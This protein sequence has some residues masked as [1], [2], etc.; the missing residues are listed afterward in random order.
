ML[1][2][3]Y[4]TK[5]GGRLMLTAKAKEH[6]VAHPEVGDLLDEVAGLV[7]LPRD[8]SFLVRAVD[9]GRLVGRSGCIPADRVGA[10][11]KA[12]FALRVGRRKPSRVVIG[13]LGPEVNTVVVLA[14]A[15]REP[16]TY[17]LITAY[18]GALAPK[19][20]W[21]ATP[22]IEREQALEFW[23]KNALVYDPEVMGE[24]FE[25]TWQDIINS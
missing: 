5:C 14:F 23:G 9:L 19:E 1:R 6:L 17:A 3:F 15:G 16:G 25:S 8:G 18:V 22:G 24:Q 4:R 21:D 11:G 20:P 10:E 12:K 7:E 2:D 13:A